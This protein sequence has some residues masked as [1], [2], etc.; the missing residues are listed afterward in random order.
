MAEYGL[1]A[2]LRE[3]KKSTRF[4]ETADTTYSSSGARG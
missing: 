2:E 4:D 3:S 1:G